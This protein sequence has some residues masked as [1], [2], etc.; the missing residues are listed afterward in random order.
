MKHDKLFLFFKDFIMKIIKLFPFISIALFTGCQSLG[1]VSVNQVKSYSSPS[2]VVTKLKLNGSDG[3]GGSYFYVWNNGNTNDPESVYP[4]NALTAYCESQGGTFKRVYKSFMEK[5]Q[6]E[7]ARNNLRTNNVAEAIGGFG[8]RV[9]NGK[10]WDVSIEPIR[11]YR[12]NSNVYTSRKVIL[13]TKI[14]TP[15]QNFKVYSDIQNARIQDEA[16]KQKIIK[17]QYA[18]ESEIQ[19]NKARFIQA[20]RPTSKDTGS[21]ICKDAIIQFP[22]NVKVFGQQQYEQANGIITG[23]VEQFSNNGQNIKIRLGGWL[24]PQG[25]QSSPHVLFNGMGLEAGKV[26]WESNQEWY[27]CKY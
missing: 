17:E 2:E 22:T 13:Q 15:E 12:I 23:Y 21:K 8:C 10:N 7:D 18:R 27:K 19:A 9:P 20:N 11:E 26:I 6:F 1:P 25:I 24:T 4:K 14:L 5:M 16:A 3:N